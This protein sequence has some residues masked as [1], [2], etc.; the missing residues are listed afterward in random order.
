MYYVIKESLCAI[1]FCNLTSVDHIQ[2]VYCS[3][4]LP[5]I[6]FCYFLEPV[7]ILCTLLMNDTGKVLDIH[8]T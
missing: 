5:H 4:Y 1:P 8:I 3:L 6:N 7:S 2:V